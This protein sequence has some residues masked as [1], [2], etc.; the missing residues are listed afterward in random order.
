[1]QNQDSTE[2]T[3]R[4]FDALQKLK[5]NGIIRG[6]QTFARKYNIDNRNFYKAEK[7]MNRN[8]FQTSWLLYLVRDY[9]VSAHWLLTGE[10]S[11]LR[12]I[13]GK[14]FENFANNLQRKNK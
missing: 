8:I 6:K 5:A 7:D 12:T 4:F 2:I 13:F 14:D 11:F 3:K 1:M 10:G 9:Y